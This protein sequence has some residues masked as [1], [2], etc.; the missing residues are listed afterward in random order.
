[1]VLQRNVWVALFAPD[2]LKMADLPAIIES[3][4]GRLH[5]SSLFA[6]GWWTME[7]VQKTDSGMKSERQVSAERVAC[8]FCL[9]YLVGP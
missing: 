9:H 2:S 7:V 8:H 1:M 4:A 3:A 6:R 5:E